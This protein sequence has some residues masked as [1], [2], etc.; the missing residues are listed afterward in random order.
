MINRSCYEAIF[1]I[2]LI[3]DKY[4]IIRVLI[5]TVGILHQCLEFPF[6]EHCKATLGREVQGV[7]ASKGQLPFLFTGLI[8]FCKTREK[9]ARNITTMEYF[10]NWKCQKI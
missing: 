3:N 8:V 7:K 2:K 10:K 1:S 4:Y 9:L 6:C 5:H